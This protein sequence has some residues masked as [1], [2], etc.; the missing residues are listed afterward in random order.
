MPA[1]NENT[2]TRRR[3]AQYFF[4]W[5]RQTLNN[6]FADVS[7]LFTTARKTCHSSCYRRADEKHLTP[8][9]NVNKLRVNSLLSTTVVQNL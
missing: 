9:I 8:L 6:N 1:S 7:T 2:S 3:L 4:S 5:N